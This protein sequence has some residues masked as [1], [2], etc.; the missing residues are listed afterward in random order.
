MISVTVSDYFCASAAHRKLRYKNFLFASAV[1]TVQQLSNE[2]Q[3]EIHK[4]AHFLTLET[5]TQNLNVRRSSNHP[6]MVGVRLGDQTGLNC[7]LNSLLKFIYQHAKYLSHNWFIFSV[8]V[9]MGNRWRLK[10]E[11]LTVIKT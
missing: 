9:K 6:E 1:V 2:N 3:D 5:F 10:V 7:L 4:S 11:Q 8:I